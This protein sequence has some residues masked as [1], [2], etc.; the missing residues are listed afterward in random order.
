MRKGQTLL[1]LAALPAERDVFSASQEVSS[2][3]IERTAARRKVDRAEQLLRDKAGSV[4][5]LEDAQ[6]V[7][8]QAEAALKMA[9][10]RLSLINNAGPDADV[11]TLTPLIL[12][13]PHDGVVKAVSTAPQQIV[14]AGA[15]LCEVSDLDPVWV[16]V[17]VYAGEAE[18]FALTSPVRVQSLAAHTGQV[19]SLAEPVSGPLSANPDTASVDLFFVMANPTGAFR[20][21][22]KVSVWLSLGTEAESLVVP[23]SAIL[24]DTFGGTWVYEN[25][26]PDTFVRRRVEVKNVV[27]DEA[28]ITRG[29][30]VGS[31][32]VSVGAAELFGTEFGVG[33]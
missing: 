31:P 32:V 33:K 13:A 8:A 18:A 21:G 12:A 22:Q 1:R 3:Q 23:F 20:P 26:A 11:S 7:L 2:R 16:R 28:V 14:A 24:Y 19:F 17:S 5:D 30:A 27:H 29:L 15:L 10:A 9:T 6:A 4:R 25:P